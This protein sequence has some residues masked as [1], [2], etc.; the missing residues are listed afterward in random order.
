MIMTQHSEENKDT[1]CNTSDCE[2]SV[3]V[4]PLRKFLY[5]YKPKNVLQ[6]LISY[7]MM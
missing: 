5:N 3:E 2:G 4:I 6:M 1:F 7:F